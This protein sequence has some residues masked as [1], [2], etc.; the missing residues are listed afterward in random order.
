[1]ATLALRKRTTIGADITHRLATEATALNK[2]SG[3]PKKL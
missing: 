3:D 1:M 2:Q